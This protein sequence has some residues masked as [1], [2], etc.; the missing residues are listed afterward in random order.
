MQTKPLNVK[1]RY[2]LQV[3]ILSVLSYY[4]VYHLGCSLHLI[5]APKS[6][7]ETHV[8][9]SNTD[10]SHLLLYYLLFCGHKCRQTLQSIPIQVGRSGQTHKYPHVAASCTITCI[11]V[12]AIGGAANHCGK[13]SLMSLAVKVL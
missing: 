12:Y 5:R 6:S 11:Y 1:C 8:L 2:T 3:V 9:N 4:D 7:V 13:Q 10:V